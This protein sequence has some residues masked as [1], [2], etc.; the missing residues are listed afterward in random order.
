MK[1]PKCKA[2]EM[3]ATLI[4]CIGRWMWATFK[5]EEEAEAYVAWLK[6]NGHD[7]RYIHERLGLDGCEE[8]LVR[9]QD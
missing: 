3:G 9:F 6:E 2:Q 4:P 8:Y 1:C 5:M 7:N